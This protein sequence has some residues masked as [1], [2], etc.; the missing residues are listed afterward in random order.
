MT[1][2]DT[3]SFDA[4]WAAW[5]ERGRVHDQ[6]VRSRLMIWGPAIAIAAAI[7]FALLR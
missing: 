3:A 6:R 1:T 5:L 7:A 2:I 4:R